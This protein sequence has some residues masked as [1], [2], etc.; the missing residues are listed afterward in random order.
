MNKQIKWL[1]DMEQDKL[2]S[3]WYGGDMV[4][5]QLWHYRICITAAGDIRAIIKGET[6]CDKNNGGMFRQ[7]LNENG[8]YNDDDLQKAIENGEVIFLDNNWF[9]III[10]DEDIKD[11]IYDTDPVVDLVPNDDFS[12][13]DDYIAG[14]GGRIE[15]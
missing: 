5:I 1:Q 13:L 6:Y 14:E 10:W 4:N 12:W 3:V 11:Y 7:Y 2:D 15:Y 9:E 8:I